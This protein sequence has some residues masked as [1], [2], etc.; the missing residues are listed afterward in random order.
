MG[1]HGCVIVVVMKCYLPLGMAALIVLTIL[2]TAPASDDQICDFGPSS[3]GTFQWEVVNDDVMGGLS[4]GSIR[5]SD[6]GVLVFSG[7]LSL[8]NNGGFSSVRSGS[9]PQDLSGATGL[10]LRVRGDGRTYQLR[11]TTDL[12]V[13]QR[14]IA[15][16]APITTTEGRWTEVQ[17]PFSSLQGTWRGEVVPRAVFDPAK[18]D[19][20]GFQLS[21][22]RDGP[23]SLEVDWIKRY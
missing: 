20:V 23:F 10:K 15:F 19:G 5:I 22:Q 21:D 18:V 2:Q 7:R 16:M 3:L 11:L 6:D 13:N 12:R 1:T 17:V 4:Q 14:R 9:V 8:E